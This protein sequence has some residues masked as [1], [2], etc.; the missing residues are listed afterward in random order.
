MLAGSH[1]MGFR[2]ARPK[3]KVAFVLWKRFLGIDRLIHINQ[4]MM[5]AAV[6]V[7]IAGARNADVRNPKRHQNRL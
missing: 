6:L 1:S 4:Q 5:M 7:I 2:L 3:M